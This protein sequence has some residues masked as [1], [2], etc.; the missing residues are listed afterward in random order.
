LVQELTTRSPPDLALL[1]ALAAS[2]DLLRRHGR[3]EEATALA[4][5][6]LGLPVKGGAADVA[7]ALVERRL[8]DLGKDAGTRAA[9]PALSPGIDEDLWQHLADRGGRATAPDSD[10]YVLTETGFVLRLS[11]ADRRVVWQ[12]DLAFRQPF[13]RPDPDGRGRTLR[14][15]DQGFWLTQEAVYAC[16]FVDGVV[17]AIDTATGKR[18]W[19]HTEW[20]AVSPPLVRP[21]HDICVC[22]A[23]S[24]G[25]L[26]ILSAKDG[27]LV[28]RVPAPEVL[29]ER[30]CEALPELT[31]IHDNEAGG[32]V[33][34]TDW[35]QLGPSGG[36]GFA[37]RNYATQRGD[38]RG[39]VHIDANHEGTHAYNLATGE[40]KITDLRLKGA[41]AEA[42]REAV[43]ARGATARDRARAVGAAGELADREQSLPTLLKILKDP[44]E[45]SD[46]RAET[47][48][49][50]LESGQE[51]G[52]DAVIDALSDAD[53]HVRMEALR[54]LYNS[55]MAGG[56][57][58]PS[59]LG[60]LAQLAH[61][62][63]SLVAR[64]ALHCL[65]S[66]GGIETKP[67]I[68]DLLDGPESERRTGVALALAEA[69]D[70]AMVPLILPLLRDDLPAEKQM[71][72]LR[73]LSALGEPKARDLYL[74]T[75]DTAQWLAK[76]AEVT[77]RGPTSREVHEAKALV[78]SI[79]PYAPDERLVPFLEEF[80]K[81]YQGKLRADICRALG[82]IGSAR[83]VPFLIAMLPPAG[84][85]PFAGTWEAG[86]GPVTSAL[87]QITGQNCGDKREDWQAWWDAHRT[88]F[89]NPG[90]PPAA[91]GAQDPPR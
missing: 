84:G 54:A 81:H 41:P 34:W 79:G 61:G 63:D 57:I 46:V 76:A 89:A 12:Y 62:Q 40:V 75:I 58:P 13:P 78:S 65:L 8:K 90:Q 14:V 59:A 31:V 56:H 88:E 37:K 22:V 42:W 16:N 50:I 82:Q 48:E 47:I 71:G 69:G 44:N 21:Q 1:K 29:H 86:A 35:L 10:L 66:L 27:S 64:P 18:L 3:T 67:L 20:T 87:T 53:G 11:E 85:P 4:K 51:E 43:A 15:A 74:G 39:L 32:E 2:F 7:R 25:E 73:I 23:N 55:K 70:K 36:W 52:F 91:P 38:A 80:S 17:H 49:S 26:V 6:A 45:D 24:F 83:S 77:Q 68:Q 19:T 30:Y 28:R 9:A 72:I 33:H 5:R 60:R